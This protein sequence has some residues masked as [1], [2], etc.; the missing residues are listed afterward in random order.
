MFQQVTRVCRLLKS[1]YGLKQ[2]PRQWFEKFSLSLKKY[3][4]VQSRNDHSLFTLTRG[5]SILALL[6]YV[7]DMVIAGN[8]TL[9][10][11]KL[12]K[13]LSTC[14]SIKDLGTLKYFLGLELARSPQGI[15]LCQRKYTLDLLKETWMS[16]SKTAAF[17][18]PQQHQLCSNC[19][20]PLKDPRQYRRLIGRLIYLT[21]SR[22]DITYAVQFL[23]QFMQTPCHPHL[24]A[25]YH[26]LRYLRALLGKDFSFLQIVIFKLKLFVML[27]RQVVLRPDD[28]LQAITFSL[29]TLLSL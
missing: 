9:Q 18:I 27:T 20:E 22:P 15:S 12:K 3:G 23:S 4:F 10:I 6:V 29:V 5:T 14:F 25:A 24:D 13:Y 8:D 28:P 7:D 1:L 21:I 17:P 19:G 2:A 16:G 26:V 11:Q